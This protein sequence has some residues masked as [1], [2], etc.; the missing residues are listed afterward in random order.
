MLPAPSRGTPTKIGADI[1]KYAAQS[2]PTVTT[3]AQHWKS[4]AV[5]PEFLRL[6]KAN[7]GDTAKL[8]PKDLVRRFLRVSVMQVPHLRYLQIRGDDM[9]SDMATDVASDVA[10]QNR[11]V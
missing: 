4:D 6:F 10:M 1:H 5:E 8:D 7:D 9:A 2:H 3:F 11:L